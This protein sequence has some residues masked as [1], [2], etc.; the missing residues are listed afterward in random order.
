MLSVRGIFNG[1][2][3]ELSENVP[4]HDKVAVI[5]TFL[6]D[7]PPV[8]VPDIR[9]VFEDII[10]IDDSAM[11]SVVL[12]EIDYMKD[13]PKALKGASEELKEKFRNN[14]G[15][16]LWEQIILE[17]DLLGAIPRSQVEEAQRHIVDKIRTLEATGQLT[18]NRDFEEEELV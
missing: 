6:E 4:Y 8:E 18:I 13:I 15:E 11:R 10:Y 9:F 7:E 3:V 2:T 17:M 14:I 16:R 1:K 12:K 5:V